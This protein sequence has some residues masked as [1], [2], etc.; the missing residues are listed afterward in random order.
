MEQVVLDVA[1][2]P[3]APLDAAATFYSEYLP[4]ARAA[5]AE[6]RALVLQFTP[7]GHEHRGWRLAAVQELAR[8]AAPKRVNGIAG[9]DP[10]AIAETLVY[11]AAAPGIT[12]Q[13]LAVDGKSGETR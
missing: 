7:A 6:T 8:E 2:S 9:D 12:G 10:R 11:L 1:S 3:D 4:R 13:L 5:L